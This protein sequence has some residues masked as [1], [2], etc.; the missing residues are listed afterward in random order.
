M[1]DALCSA[2]V[3][4]KGSRRGEF[5]A[6]RLRGDLEVSA[7]LV[8]LLEVRATRARAD[9]VGRKEVD[10]LDVLRARVAQAPS[11]R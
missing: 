9:G 3:A 10:M 5:G 6:A 11:R 4:S 7:R 8:C 2:S 1:N